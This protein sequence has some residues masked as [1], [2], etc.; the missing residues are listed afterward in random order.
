MVARHTRREL[1]SLGIAAIAAIAVGVGAYHRAGGFEP[2]P[3]EVDVV[4]ARDR[5]EEPEL[6]GTGTDDARDVAVEVA[7][8]ELRFVLPVGWVD[9]AP[10]SGVTGADLFPGD[11]SLATAFDGHLEA[12]TTHGAILFALNTDRANQAQL[13]VEYETGTEIEPAIAAGRSLLET[14]PGITLRTDTPIDLASETGHLF[15]YERAGSTSL[16]LLQLVV[17]GSVGFYVIV[18][19]STESA[20]ID[21]L[22]DLAST[23][24]VT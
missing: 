3:A 16:D 4:V 17:P 21:E 2:T 13:R 20:V 5:G 24:E 1:L 22:V 6:P 15:R 18:A 7:G 11:P 10:G 23:V 14:T 12:A 19:Q 8:D 9:S